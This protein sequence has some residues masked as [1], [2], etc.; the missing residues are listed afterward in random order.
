MIEIVT[1]EKLKEH[2][3]NIFGELTPPPGPLPHCLINP[4]GFTEARER[5]LRELC[6]PM[7]RITS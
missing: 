5:I 1:D 4:R 3:I 7:G 6:G 2:G